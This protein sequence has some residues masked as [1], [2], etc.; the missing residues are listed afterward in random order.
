M[1][2]SLA[3]VLTHW[4]AEPSAVC[5]LLALV[6]GFVWL[7]RQPALSVSRGRQACFVTAVGL[8][9]L[10][11]LS[12]LD[13]I[14]DRYLLFGHMIQHLLLV[15]AVAP[16][17][18][19]AVPRKWGARL[20]M[21]PWLAFAA[22]NLVFG[23]SHTP[24]WYEATLVH[25]PLHIVEHVLYLA[26][27]MLNWLPILNPAREQRLPEPM[28]MLYLFFETLPM[29]VVGALLALSENAVYPFYLR[30]PRL[31]GISAIQDQSMAGLL[32]WIGG[33]FFYL[34][35]LT[36]VFFGWANREMAPDSIPLPPQWERLGAH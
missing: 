24:S 33:S 10:A 12:P 27:G 11:L 18:A 17:L 30:A 15:L 8:L 34:G 35:A 5:G 3:T 25:E 31:A 23:L 9:V 32:M 6:A 4:N 22:F 1:P 20:T 28:Q 7:Q 26:A 13:E 36:V 21:N 19:L 29:F 14:S 16:L 2:L